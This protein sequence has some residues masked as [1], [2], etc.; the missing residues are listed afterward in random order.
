MTAAIPPAA[1]QGKSDLTR[2]WNGRSTC[3]FTYTDRED[4]TRWPQVV[5]LIEIWLDER[6]CKYTLERSDPIRS[7]AIQNTGYTASRLRDDQDILFSL[8]TILFQKYPHFHCALN[9]KNELDPWFAM[10]VWK[11]IYTIIDPEDAESESEIINDLNFAITNFQGDFD[12]WASKIHNLFR[13][14]HLNGQQHNELVLC[15][16]MQNSMKGWITTHQ[17]NPGLKAHM[18]EIWLQGEL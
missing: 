17:A 6:D 15:T 3:P 2:N 16:H 13:Q 9:S 10:A 18:W 5:R 7:M 14:L 1:R 11:Q 8:I 4:D 12:P